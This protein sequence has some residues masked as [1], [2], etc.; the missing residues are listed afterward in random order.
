MYTAILHFSFFW[1]EKKITKA[2]EMSTANQQGR[3]CTYYVLQM[4]QS[5]NEPK[6]QEKKIDVG[7]RNEMKQ[8]KWSTFNRNVF[9][10]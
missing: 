8:T 4:K 3:F 9:K 1:T 2:R 7:L 10:K 5:G 6:I